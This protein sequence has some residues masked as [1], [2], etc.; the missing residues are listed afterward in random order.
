MSLE[1]LELDFL[2]DEIDSLEKAESYLEKNEGIRALA[3]EMAFRQT[4]IKIFLL[5][6]LV[7]ENDFNIS[8][9]QFKR[10]NIHIFAEKLLANI[11]QA[12]EHR[13]Q[14]EEEFE[15]SDEEWSEDENIGKA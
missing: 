15:N 14:E 6:G 11:K 8:V 3:E 13:K 2:F 5:S 7:T 1:D 9:E 4:V 12:Q 10:D